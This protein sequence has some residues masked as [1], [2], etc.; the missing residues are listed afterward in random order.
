MASQSCAGRKACAASLP[1]AL[2]VP[3]I[4]MRTLDVAFQVIIAQK[5]FGTR[6][7]RTFE[8][9]RIGVRAEMLCQSCLTIESFVAIV[10]WTFQSLLPAARCGGRGRCRGRSVVDLRFLLVLRVRHVKVVHGIEVVLRVNLHLRLCSRRCA[11]S[12]L[13]RQ[14][15]RRKERK[16]RGT[17]Y[18]G[19]SVHPIAECGVKRAAF[20]QKSGW[21]KFWGDGHVTTPRHTVTCSALRLRVF[22]I[23]LRLRFPGMHHSQRSLFPC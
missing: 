13:G 18:F 12:F 8:W 4:A 5:G 16:N 17:S 15:Q 14:I 9:S 23:F 11:L 1:G 2:V 7:M 21:A 6:G 19:S 3:D 22:F 10:P 20:C